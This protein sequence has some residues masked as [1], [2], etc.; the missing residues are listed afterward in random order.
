MSP[1]RGL[2]RKVSTEEATAIQ[3]VHIVKRPREREKEE[4]V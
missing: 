1:R 3:R 4:R 2:Y